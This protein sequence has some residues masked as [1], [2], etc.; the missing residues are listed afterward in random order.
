MLECR[1]KQCLPSTKRFFLKSF[2]NSCGVLVTLSFSVLWH[3][4]AAHEISRNLCHSG[5]RLLPLSALILS[6]CPRDLPK[7]VLS[8]LLTQRKS[9]FSASHRA[10]Q[11]G[12]TRMS[13]PSSQDGCGSKPCSRAVKIIKLTSTW[14]SNWFN[15]QRLVIAGSWSGDRQPRRSGSQTNFNSSTPPWQHHSRDAATPTPGFDTINPKGFRG[16]PPCEQGS[17]NGRNHAFKPK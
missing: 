16:P 6:H 5:I 17:H 1:T 12:P 4:L 10:V 7:Q 14:Q 15:V 13:L 3:S 11:L 9:L 8:D 2:Q